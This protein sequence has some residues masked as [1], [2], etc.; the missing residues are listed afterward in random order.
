[1]G[2]NRQI[3]YCSDSIVATQVRVRRI[4]C[5]GKG[6]GQ[7]FYILTTGI[8]KD[9]MIKQLACNMPAH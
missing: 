8:E 9:D 4:D 3:D 6:C 1:M 2:L 7:A 5:M